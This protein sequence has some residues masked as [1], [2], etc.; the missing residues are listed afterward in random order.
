VALLCGLLICLA[1]APIYFLRIVPMVFP[2]L[3]KV[4][5]DPS[6]FSQERFFGKALPN[7]S[8]V[9]DEI[10]VYFAK[11]NKF[12]RV[13]LDGSDPTHLFEADMPVADFLI[14]PDGRSVLISTF[15]DR[16]QYV[17]PLAKLYL[18]SMDDRDVWLV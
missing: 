3:S 1:L 8:W 16:R 2:T 7:S 15:P 4:P 9:E 11:D 18:V 12:G 6:R 5:W 17:R 14:S 10:P 13:N